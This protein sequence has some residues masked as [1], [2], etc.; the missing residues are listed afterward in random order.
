L[1][2]GEGNPHPGEP[3]KRKR[4][5]T[6]KNPQ[7]GI[8]GQSNR[9]LKEPSGDLGRGGG[10][11]HKG[12]AQW[13]KINETGHLQSFKSTRGPQTKKKTRH[14]GA[15]RSGPNTKGEKG[16]VQLKVNEI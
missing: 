2:G 8:R 16:A 13:M 5:S 10:P 6:G 1:R 11:L 4:E 9:V 14:Y 15:K 7:G 3:P 12:P